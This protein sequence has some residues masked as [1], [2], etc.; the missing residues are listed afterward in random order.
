MNRRSLFQEAVIARK[1][2]YII[3]VAGDSGS[4]KTSFTRSIRHLVGDELVSTI[5]LDDY[6]LLDREQ[7]KARNITPLVPEAN[8]IPGLEKDLSD[9]KVGK[10]VRKMIYNHT[11]GVL[12]GPVT[13]RPSKIVILEGLHTLSTGALREA[14]DFSLYVDPADDVRRE[15]KLKRDME[16]RG[17]SEREVMEEIQKRQ[18]DYKKYIA[19]QMEH[20][21]AV[22][23]IAFSSYGRNLGWQKNIYRTTLS[24][25]PFTG[26][27]PRADLGL[28]LPALM[29]F[30][31]GQ[32]S[33]SYSHEILGGRTLSAL[34]FD[35]E[36]DCN[37]I[38]GIMDLFSGES[39]VSPC[40]ILGEGNMLT[41][42]DIVRALLA[43]RIMQEIVL[44]A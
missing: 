28:S 18:D 8:N 38:S 36:F 41:P 9:L 7:R 39:G 6:H 22:I 3:G 20:A 44:G 23:H 2:V 11:K 33:F 27:I 14:V 17:Y 25:I 35:G 15:W 1:G 24:Q 37:F 12:E 10:P 5:S 42:P 34:T 31:P 43:W 30:V 13:F 40:R 16:K 4:G 29:T 26:D 21:D 19:P 32:F